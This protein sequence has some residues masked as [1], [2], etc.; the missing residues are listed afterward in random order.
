MRG[1]KA[2]LYEGG[3]R[4]PCFLRWPAGN[5]PAGD[6]GA[7]TQVQDVLPTLVELCGLSVPERTRLDGTS[8]AKLLRGEDQ[9]E[10][11]DRKL[12]VQ[13]G[14]LFRASPV[15]WDSAVL[16][17][18]WRLVKGKELYDLARDPGQ[19]RDLS[20][21]FPEIVARLRSHY[22]RWWSEIEPR[23]SEP[24]TITV[25]AEEENPTCLSSMDW[26]ADRIVPAA[27]D[28]D[29]R[30]LGGSKA[31][32]DSLPG[33]RP[34]VVLNAPWNVLVARAGTYEIS[35]RRW[36]EEA[37]AA[38]T[39]GLPAL[40]VTDGQYPPGLPLPVAR[41]RLKVA[42]VDQS[43]DV[44]PGD[45]AVS[46]TVP[47]PKGRTQLHTWFYDADGKELC[48]AFYVSVRRL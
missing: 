39:A 24:S 43:C 13:Y 45:K 34:Q 25:G 20:S 15:K 29:I 23:I 12:V 3:H 41:A 47:L 28:Y 19:E 42:G 26:W 18:R 16:W 37:D 44:N 2:S 35:L 9:P 31:K 32:I 46:F 17:R 27:Q 11:A 38:I 1:A 36:P 7:L 8:L 5:L 40:K 22:E 4:V 33:G 21:Q 30:Q 14:G 6:R 10:L 48:G